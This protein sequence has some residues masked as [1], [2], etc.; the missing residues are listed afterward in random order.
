MISIKFF[1]K[2]ENLFRDMETH[3][4]GDLLDMTQIILIVLIGCF[5]FTNQRGAKYFW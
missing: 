5:P 1:L 2:I 4:E 3:I